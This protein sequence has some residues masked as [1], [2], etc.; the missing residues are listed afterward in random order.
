M[1]AALEIGPFS[2]V[3][4]GSYLAFVDPDWFAT[5][6]TRLQERWAQRRRATS[7]RP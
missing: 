5:T 1:W 7:A 2:W 4:I 6:A 3:M